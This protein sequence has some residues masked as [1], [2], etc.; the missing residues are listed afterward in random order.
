MNLII[1]FKFEY[2][3]FV[4]TVLQSSS[5]IKVDIYITSKLYQNYNDNPI[6][7]H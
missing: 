5:L 6:M 2:K 1:N 7:Y 4:Y 3:F